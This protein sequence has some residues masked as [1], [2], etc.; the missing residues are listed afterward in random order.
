MDDRYRFWWKKRAQCS[1]TV[2]P[3]GLESMTIKFKNMAGVLIVLFSG[4]IIS[5]I[6]LVMEVK[7]KW[8]IDLILE[9]GVRI[10]AMNNMGCFHQAIGIIQD[11]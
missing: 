5:F 8:V 9:T 11:L 4:V 6:L 2:K 3:K 10:V 1:T 7:F